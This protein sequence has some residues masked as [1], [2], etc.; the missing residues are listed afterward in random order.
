MDE[1]E[2]DR[3][4]SYADHLRMVSVNCDSHDAGTL[5]MVAGEMEALT[6]LVDDLENQ[7]AEG[8]A[9]MDQAEGRIAELDGAIRAALK[10]TDKD[11]C[12]HILLMVLS[13]DGSAYAD[14]VRAA[15][16][17]RKLDPNACS[18]LLEQALDKLE[19]TTP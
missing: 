4:L 7:I 14:V 13:G 5:D 10:T 19:G 6:A 3:P 12:V 8:L 16:T 2:L 15:Q 18:L 11:E 9:G 17:L 1:S